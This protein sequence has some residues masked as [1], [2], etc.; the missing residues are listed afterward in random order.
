[1]TSDDTERDEFNQKIINI[2]GTALLGTSL[3]STATVAIGMRE[4]VI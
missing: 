1:M 3:I 2:G 4:Y